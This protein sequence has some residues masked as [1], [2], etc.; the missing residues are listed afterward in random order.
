MSPRLR[1]LL[2]WCVALIGG[3]AIVGA[4]GRGGAGGQ[5][6]GR[7]GG[8]VVVRP[9]AEVIT[10]AA[11]TSD[12]IF[13]VHRITEGNNDTL[14]FEIPKAELNK[15]YLWDTQIKKTTIGA[16]YGGQ[17]VGNRVVRWVQKG[18]RVLLENMDY[19]LV[20]DPNNPLRDE[21]DMPAI[22]R[23]F[24]VS[25]YSANGDPVIDVTSLYTQDTAEFSARGAVGGRGSDPTRTFLE[26]A[27]PYPMNV[28][29]EVTMTYTTT[30]D[31]GAAPDPAVP[32]RGGR[33]GGTRG[34]SATV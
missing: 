13:K 4:Q 34:P 26:R 29:V 18:D 8:A 20:A 24:P 12:G 33:G 19:S 32:G 27:T 15:D 30:A 28:N 22:I 17:A 31:T 5:G 23:T 9:Y 14:Y 7:A 10:S 11:K 2:V 25:A 6:G 21:A 3:A 16:G 1:T